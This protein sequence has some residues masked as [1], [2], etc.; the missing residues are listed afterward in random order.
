MV[1]EGRSYLETLN[2]VKPRLIRSEY[3]AEAVQEQIDALMEN[4][5]RTPEDQEYLAFLTWLL[6][7]WEDGKY[8]PIHVEPIEVIKNLLADN[9]LRQAD[10]VGPVFPT[11]SRASEALSGRRSLTYQYVERL[12]AFF[13]VS[14]NL[15]FPPAD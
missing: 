7:I 3:E 12:A 6:L 8:P 14:P 15:F 4:R 2:H 11:R 9:G 1:A 10:L 5:D 13:R